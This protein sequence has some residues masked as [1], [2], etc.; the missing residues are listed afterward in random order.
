MTDFGLD[1]PGLISSRVA[2]FT[3]TS[4]LAL[5]P[6]SL[7]SL[8]YQELFFLGDGADYYLPSGAEIKEVWSLTS[9]PPPCH[10]GSGATLPF[11]QI[12]YGKVS[13]ILQSQG[14]QW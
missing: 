4:R 3:A 2:D 1:D 7:L 5:G 8:G 6:L 14:P 13:V 9:I 12:H 11:M 10:G